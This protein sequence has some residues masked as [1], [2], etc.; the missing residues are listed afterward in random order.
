MLLFEQYLGEEHFVDKV[1][2]C[3]N[4][5]HCLRQGGYVFARLSFS[6]CVSA[7]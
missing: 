4:E 7:R 3:K 1:Q 2:A 5:Y 6:V